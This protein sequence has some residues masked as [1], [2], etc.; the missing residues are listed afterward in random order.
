[1]QEVLNSD[2]RPWPSQGPNRSRPLDLVD[3]EEPPHET[4]AGNRTPQPPPGS[5]LRCKGVAHSEEDP[6]TSLTALSIATSTRPKT[7]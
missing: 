5:H 3:S 1:M 7:T 4:A 6:E 2:V